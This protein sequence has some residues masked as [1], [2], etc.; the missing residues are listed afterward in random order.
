MDRELGA[1]CLGGCRV[2]VTVLRGPAT[3]VQA[4]FPAACLFK[5]IKEAFGRLLGTHHLLIASALLREIQSR[6]PDCGDDVSIIEAVEDPVAANHDEVEVRLNLQT[7]YLR[8][9]YYHIRVAPEAGS[10][11]LDVP[12]SPSHR[13]PSREDSQGTLNVN[14]LL[15]RVHGWAREGLSSVDLP[16]RELDP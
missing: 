9:A 4:L 6:V 14:V 7:S 3:A 1:G 8:L 10:F 13:K 11:R 5:L 12:K 2:A 16:S 15:I